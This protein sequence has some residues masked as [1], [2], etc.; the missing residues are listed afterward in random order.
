MVDQLHR[1]GCLRRLVG[2]REPRRQVAF[3]VSFQGRYGAAVRS[4]VLWAR[5]FAPHLPDAS[6]MR[7]VFKVPAAR[8]RKPYQVLTNPEV[9]AL[10]VRSRA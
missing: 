3:L 10:L 2:F 4:F 5:V 6:M 1:F 9:L 7:E 8:V